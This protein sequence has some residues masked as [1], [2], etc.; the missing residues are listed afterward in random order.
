MGRLDKDRQAHGYAGASAGQ[1]QADTDSP[2][3]L[4]LL[5]GGFGSGSFRGPRPSN[6]GD[7]RLV[8][9][10]HSL[11]E[12]DRAAVPASLTETVWGPVLPS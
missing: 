9:D 7:K 6:F 8:L 1:E 10:T 4:P 2:Y 5:H 3:L 12:P 11:A